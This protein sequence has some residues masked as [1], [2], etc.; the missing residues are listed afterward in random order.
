MYSAPRS[1]PWE[2]SNNLPLYWSLGHLPDG[3]PSWSGTPAGA[4]LHRIEGY[5]DVLREFSLGSVHG[6]ARSIVCIRRGGRKI[7]ANYWVVGATMGDVKLDRDFV[8][9]GV[10]VLGWDDEDHPQRKL[11]SRIQPGDRIAIKRRQ[12]RGQRNILILHLGVVTSI[13]F[14]TLRKR[15]GPQTSSFI[16]TVNWVA[17]DLDRDIAD[18]KGCY[19]SI[20]G[21]FG[22]DPADLRW[23]QEVFYL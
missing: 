10:W 18:G 21:P 14:R 6:T 15:V 16:C 5:L 1:G 9:Q 3:V 2:G 8:E 7:M 20:H 12:G 23:I 19:K 17:T 4:R 22:P 11:A 13:P